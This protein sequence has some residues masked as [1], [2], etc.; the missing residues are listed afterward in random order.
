M[1]WATEAWGEVVGC[2]CCAEGGEDEG[3]AEAVMG[4]CWVEA[5]G[6]SRVGVRLW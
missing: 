4:G 5:L 6:R 2:E 1:A 3:E